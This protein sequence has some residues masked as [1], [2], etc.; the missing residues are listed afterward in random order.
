MRAAIE[1]AVKDLADTLEG[2]VAA[3]KEVLLDEIF[4]V[5]L[6]VS[7][8]EEKIKDLKK[9]Y[10]IYPLCEVDYNAVRKG[11]WVTVGKQNASVKRYYITHVQDIGACEA[12]L[13]LGTRKFDN[14]T[15]EAFKAEWQNKWGTRDNDPMAI[16]M[17]IELW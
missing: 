10:L 8:E 3:H 12:G 9:R 7:E 6:E 5:R 4:N 13:A 14:S 15:I 1:K 16:F 2:I 11:A 17:E